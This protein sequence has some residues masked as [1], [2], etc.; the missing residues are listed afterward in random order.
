MIEETKGL[1]RSVNEG[2]NEKMNEWRKE[3]AKRGFRMKAQRREGM[4]ER[5]S[6]IRR[7]VGLKARRREGMNGET[8]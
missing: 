6:M 7:G 4:I 3:R 5:N 8:K 2:T 1:K